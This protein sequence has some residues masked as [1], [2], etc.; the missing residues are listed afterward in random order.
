MTSHAVWRLD[1]HNFDP[2][3]RDKLMTG[4]VVPR[5]EHAT[6]LRRRPGTTVEAIAVMNVDELQRDLADIAKG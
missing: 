5:V 1:N 2:V 3:E 4:Q 6:G